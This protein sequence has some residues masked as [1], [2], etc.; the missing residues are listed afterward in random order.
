MGIPKLRK[1]LSTAFESTF[2]R[3]GSRLVD[4]LYI[5]C[6]GIIHSAVGKNRQSAVQ[7]D[8]YPDL[9]QDCIAAIKSV[10][11]HYRPKKILY[12][13]VDGPVPM[14]KIQESRERRYFGATSRNIGDYSGD[15]ITPGT[16]FM[17]LLDEAMKELDNNSFGVLKMIYSS[18]LVPG[19]GEHKIM[20]YIRENKDSL[21]MH[22][23]NHVMY[24]NDSDLILLGLCTGLGKMF[25]AKDTVELLDSR[26]LVIDSSKNKNEFSVDVLR[27]SINAS[28]GDDREDEFI[29][30][31]S[32]I[33]NDFLPRSALMSDVESGLKFIVDFL[34]TGSVIEDDCLSL[35]IEL[36]NQETLAGETLLSSIYERS[37][38]SNSTQ[39][40]SR[41]LNAVATVVPE[42]RDDAFRYHWYT[43]FLIYHEFNSRALTTIAKACVEYIRGLHWVFN[44]YTLGQDAVTW[45]W[46]YP[47]HHAPLFR[48]LALT[49]ESVYDGR[50]LGGT[51][52]LDDVAPF[53]DEVRFTCLHHLVSVM[54]LQSI[55]T[56]PQELHFFYS[57]R[58]PLLH[59]MPATVLVNDDMVEMESQVKAILPKVDY[60]AI[61]EALSLHKFENK[62]ITEHSNTVDITRSKPL[63]LPVAKRTEKEGTREERPSLGR[64]RGIVQSP[65]VD[66]SKYSREPITEEQKKPLPG[67]RLIGR[68]PQGREVLR[69]FGRGGRGRG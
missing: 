68:G 4:C 31:C 60:Y 14:C 51:S 33:G 35:F 39:Y 11:N 44:Y 28:I 61:M 49:V 21:S 23:G 37:Q 50:I 32:L 66:V 69:Q 38:D 57:D 63:R 7:E 64:G 18:H 53:K 5:D 1:A 54:P 27:N 47:Y 41:V 19:E 48:D 55:D 25:I 30:A 43:K 2:Y 40:R 58:S 17:V 59:F 42:D 3:T 24:G 29:F 16:K 22:S 6:N 45:L 13:A 10:T 8:E 52:L 20:R 15:L 65:T 56:L 26:N 12:L 9:V 34:K 67:G 62:F 46:Y 36:S